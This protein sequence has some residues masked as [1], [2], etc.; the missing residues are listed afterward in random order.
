MNWIRRERG[1]L[2]NMRGR[3]ETQTMRTRM[4]ATGKNACPTKME[5]GKWGMGKWGKNAGKWWA[6]PTLQS[7]RHKV[8]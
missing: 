3:H 2:V 8:V 6:K 4:S 5:I 1:R 7:L